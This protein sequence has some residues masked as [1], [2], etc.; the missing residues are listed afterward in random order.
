MKAIVYLI[1]P[2]S[3]SIV[4]HYEAPAIPPPNC[5]SGA[6]VGW[7]SGEKFNTDR[8][9][10]IRRIIANDMIIVAFL[11]Y[12]YLFLLVSK[13][14]VMFLLVNPFYEMVQQLFF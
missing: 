1:N 8:C 13:S 4:A 9:G 3:K 7:R 6:S 12:L 5:K 11:R 2:T 14:Q 10:V